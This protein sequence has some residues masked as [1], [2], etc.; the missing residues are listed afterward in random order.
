MTLARKFLD[1]IS[2]IETNIRVECFVVNENTLMFRCSPMSYFD[3]LYMQV[4][5]YFKS[6]SSLL[7]VKS[8]IKRTTSG[9][10]V[11]FKTTDFNNHYTIDD[12]AKQ[13]EETIAVWIN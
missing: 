4:D 1:L 3:S 2:L 7:G 10:T 13:A 6:N 9:I 8:K 12:V 11:K 5:K